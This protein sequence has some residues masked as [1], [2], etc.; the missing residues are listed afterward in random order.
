MQ[1][2]QTEALELGLQLSPALPEYN[3]VP[4]LTPCI[5]VSCFTS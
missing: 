3:Y 5:Q 4:L 2:K 1:E